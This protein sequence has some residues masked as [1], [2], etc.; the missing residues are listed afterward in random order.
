ME[1]LSILV[2]LSLIAI[3]SYYR[4]GLGAKH[5]QEQS[6]SAKKMTN[7][8]AHLIDWLVDSY[9]RALVSSLLH[10]KKMT[11]RMTIKQLVAAVG[12][13]ML[14]LSVCVSAQTAE[15]EIG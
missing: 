13:S 9:H 12:S 11:G 4:A 8:P 15:V 6:Q 5:A 10:E 7:R 14:G 3:C 2:V 1:S